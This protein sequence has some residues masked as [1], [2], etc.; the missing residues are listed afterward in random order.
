MNINWKLRLQNKYTLTAIIVTLIGLVYTT[1][2][3]F[4]YA[5]EIPQTA[6]VEIAEKAIFLLALMGIVVDPTTDGASDSERAMS[7]TTPA[8]K[9]DA[10]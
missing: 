3:T 5:P 9:G 2:E 1:L 4:G 7:Y 10:E 8:K 6:F